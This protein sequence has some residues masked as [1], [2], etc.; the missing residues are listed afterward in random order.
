MKHLLGILT[1]CVVGLVAPDLVLANPSIS[2]VKTGTVIVNVHGLISDKGNLKVALENSIDA[3]ATRGEIPSYRSVTANIKN[4]IA[5]IIY[6]DV[7]YGDYAVRLY[8]DKN[9]NNKFDQGIFGIPLEW[10]GFSNNVMG[11]MKPPSFEK[12]KF[13]LE[14]SELEISI[15]MKR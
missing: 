2:A 1:M 12:A 3:W 10:F 11:F 9:L 15:K 6:E 7:P 13:R 4:K 5:K 14:K 8:H